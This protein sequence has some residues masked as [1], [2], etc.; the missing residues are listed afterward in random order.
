ME[1][2][3]RKRKGSKEEELKKYSKKDRKQ[4]IR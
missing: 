2:G 4:G 3:E 1:E